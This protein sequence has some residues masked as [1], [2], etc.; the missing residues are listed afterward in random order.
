MIVRLFVARVCLI[1]DRFPIHYSRKKVVQDRPAS[2]KEI[3]RISLAQFPVRRSASLS[4]KAFQ[5]A[6]FVQMWSGRSHAM[7]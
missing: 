5:K 6:S 3:Q 2:P 1:I 4:K 7:R